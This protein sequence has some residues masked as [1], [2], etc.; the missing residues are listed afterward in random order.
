MMKMVFKKNFLEVLS[1]DKMDGD[2]TVVFY[3][4]MGTSKEKECKVEKKAT[5]IDGL[6]E[7]NDATCDRPAFALYDAKTK[8]LF[9]QNDL[10]MDGKF[11]FEPCDGITIGPDKNT[12][13]TQ[14][15]QHLFSYI[16][17]RIV[18]SDREIDQ[19]EIEASCGEQIQPVESERM[20]AFA[21]GVL[22][23][24]PEISFERFVLDE[25]LECD[26]SE[27]KINHEQAQCYFDVERI[28]PDN[29]CLYLREKEVCGDRAIAPFVQMNQAFIKP[30]ISEICILFK[31]F[32]AAKQQT[33]SKREKATY[34][35]IMNKIMDLP[36][37]LFAIVYAKGHSYSFSLRQLKR[38][39]T[40]KY[41]LV[42]D[43][44]MIPIEQILRVRAGKYTIPLSQN[45]APGE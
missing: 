30:M 20:T 40:P 35:M 27:P 22:T 13:N 3:P 43:Q 39:M 14:I 7:V 38:A 18:T 17:E 33:V 15:I 29:Y 9:C 2:C 21:L 32:Q 10:L 4:D 11:S 45:N 36:D 34:L 12:L 31:A 24:Q 42:N 1:G 26:V 25:W 28:T 37:F 6:Y 16:I 23:R 19:D 8:R 41:L 44:G 5:N